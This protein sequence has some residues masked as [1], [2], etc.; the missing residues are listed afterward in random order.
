MKSLTKSIISYA[1]GAVIGLLLVIFTC[2][3][4]NDPNIRGAP[5]QNHVSLRER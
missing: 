4:A 1:I 3:L 5:P 2:D